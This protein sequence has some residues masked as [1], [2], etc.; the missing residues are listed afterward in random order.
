MTKKDEEF[1]WRTL[2]VRT[3]L[4]V[5]W[6]GITK[7]GVWSSFVVFNISFTDGK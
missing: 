3:N 2:T 1:R 6:I 5:G 4:L 7:F